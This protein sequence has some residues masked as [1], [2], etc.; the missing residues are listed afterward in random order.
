MYENNLQQPQNLVQYINIMVSYVIPMKIEFLDNLYNFKHL[1]KNEYV[2]L[3]DYI[4]YDDFNNVIYCLITNNA[5]IM[6][7]KLSPISISDIIYKDYNYILS[8]SAKSE[9]I[10]LSKKLNHSVDSE[11]KLFD[12]L[13]QITQHNYKKS[14]VSQYN[15]KVYDAC[16]NFIL[17]IDKLSEE[18]SNLYKSSN[19]KSLNSSL[20]PNKS[21]SHTEPLK[22][23]LISNKYD[24]HNIMKSIYNF[25]NNL[26]SVKKIIKKN[27][28]GNIDGD[29]D[30]D[31]GDYGDD[32]GDDDGDDNDDNDDNDE[33]KGYKS[34]K[35]N[36]VQKNNNI[37]KNNKKRKIHIEQ[38]D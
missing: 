36:N 1:R 38:I 13:K 15:T 28:N 2:F 29:G 7:I 33:Y 5:R 31:N 8:K 4:T 14:D 30:D 35:F 32:D 23:S 16:N 37:Q 26:Q 24:H 22:Y 27:D 10:D 19:D 21:A 17:D 20:V 18:F 34:L 6:I 9:L 25:I 3:F 12:L 11:Q